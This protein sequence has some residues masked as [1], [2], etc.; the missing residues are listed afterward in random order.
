MM[1]TSTKGQMQMPFHWIYVLIAGAVILLFFVS[2]V[3]KQKDSATQQLGTEVNRILES[4]VGAA[5]VSE[6]TKSVISTAGLADETLYFQCVV[7]KNGDS[8]E[9][10]MEYG[11]K[12]KGVS[13]K[14]TILPLFAPAE[15]KGTQLF[16]WSLPYTLPFKIIDFLYVTGPTMQ[17]VLVGESALGQEFLK[18][19]ESVV[20]PTSKIKFKINVEKVADV[21]SISS[22][23]G[24]AVR[25]VDYSGGAIQTGSPIPLSLQEKADRE[26]SAVVF[27]DGKKVTFFQKEGKVWKLEGAAT[28]FSLNGDLDAVRYAAIFAANKEM[29]DCGMMQAFKRAQL[30]SAVYAG[31]AEQVMGAA[32]SQQGV[33]PVK[34]SGLTEMIEKQK[35]LAESCVALYPDSCSDLVANGAQLKELNSKLGDGCIPLY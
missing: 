10:V 27:G 7:S 26:V 32:L 6:S 1:A 21:N 9:A 23:Q 4:I 33:C 2:I 34:V 13:V 28:L 31:R 30:V 11:L 15:I 3:V 29:F 20:D 5:S 14:D 24:F 16:L 8:R 22:S 25:I 19:A 35:S 18:E 17:Y 12:E